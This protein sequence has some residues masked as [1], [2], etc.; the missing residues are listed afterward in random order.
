MSGF[1][2]GKEAEHFEWA[3]CRSHGPRLGTG[4]WALGTPQPQAWL[5]CWRCSSAPALIGSLSE[6]A[7]KKHSRLRDGLSLPDPVPFAS[8]IAS[9]SLFF[10]LNLSISCRLC[11]S[12]TVSPSP[13][14]KVES[15]LMA[16]AVDEECQVSHVQFHTLTIVSLT[17]STMSLIIL[18]TSVS[19]EQHHH[20]QD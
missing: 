6:P 14:F 20:C 11:Q 13:E 1:G 3:E 15:C 9:R 12:S 10:A 5:H 16:A 17:I 8:P 7:L 18:A 19:T 2:R 4:H